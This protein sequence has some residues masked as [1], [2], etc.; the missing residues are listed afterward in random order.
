MAQS[1][2]HDHQTTLCD[3]LLMASIPSLLTLT[4]LIFFA[5]QRRG[6][7]S[8]ALLKIFSLY[9]K[10]CWLLR[11]YRGVVCLIGNIPQLFKYNKPV[12]AK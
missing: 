7:A 1:C 5:Y 10:I 8:K 2:S 12:R 11:Y 4:T 9:F 6:E 3:N